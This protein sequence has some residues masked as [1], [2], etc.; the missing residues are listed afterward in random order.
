VKVTA[1]LVSHNGARW[2]PAV[3]GGLAA[4]TRKVDAIVAVDTGSQDDSAELVERAIGAPVLRLDPRTPY[5]ESVR[6]ALESAA[7]AEPDEWVWLLHDDSNPAPECLETL[8][9]TA[10]EAPAEVAVL[11]PKHR[12]WPSLKRLLEVGVTLTGTGQRETGLERGEYDQGQHD[13]PHRV[14]AVNTAGML[15]RR[16]VLETVGLDR[17]LPVFGTDL[18]FGWRVARAG[19]STRVVPDAVIFHVEASR[20]DRRES[21][22]VEHPGRQEREGAQYT[23][24]VNSPGWTI[25]FRSARMILGGLL[26]A[27][28]LLLVR[29]PGE[30]AD[31]VAALL[32]IFLRPRRVLRAR[33]DRAGTATVSH[34]EIR[35]LLAPFWLPYRHGLDYVTDVGVAIATSVRE[36]AARRRPPGVTESTPFWERVLRTPAVWVLLLALIAGRSYFGGEPL[37]GGALLPVPDS[38]THWWQTWGSWHSDL[39]IGTHAAGPAYLLPLAIL[40]TLLLGQVGLVIQLIFVLAVPVAFVGALHLLRRVCDGHGAPLWGAATYALLPVVSGS[41][42]QGRLGTVVGAAVLPW[43]VTAALGIGAGAAEANAAAAARQAEADDRGSH[44]ADIPVDPSVAIKRWRAAWRAAL[45]AWLLVAFVPPAWLV[46]ALLA[47]FAVV[48]G[49]AEGRKRELAIVTLVPLVVVL[50][51]ALGTLRAPSAWLVEAGRAATLPA[52]P[53]FFDLILG[54]TGSVIEAPGWFAIGLPLAAVVAF[55]RSDTR[56]RVLQVWVVVLAAAIVLAASSRV[57]VTLPGVPFEFRPWPGFLILLI[58]AGFVAIAAIAGDGVLRHVRGASIGWRQ[59]VA[60]VTV[61]VAMVVP[62]LGAGWWLLR[63]SDDLLDHAPSAEIP[64]YQQELAAGNDLTGVLRITGGLDRGIDYR[65]LRSGPERLGDDGVLA[66]TEPAPEFGKL[67]ERLLSDA[68][69]DDVPLLASY[70][71]KYVYAPP[72]VAGVVSGGMD[73]ASGLGGASGPARGSRAWVVQDDTTL[74]SVDDSRAWLR[75]IWI[76]IS[77]LALVTTAVL[78]APERRR[79]R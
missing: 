18:D 9:A 34:A 73:A 63:G 78:A 10:V 52:D 68:R 39:G 65:V 2:L 1:I 60:V 11:G 16:S 50:P 46:I 28:G 17:Y 13:E 70:G 30:A 49:F 56:A 55:L 54:R 6:A 43:L 51:W 36:E 21:E 79:R 71:V 77:L 32:K 31:E 7:P 3:L 61:A 74:S 25:P 40:G 57:P 41:L 67:V 22:L 66:M 45:L 59:P 26:R 23:L 44:A 35:P 8:V 37:H 64:M 20:Q 72:P 69:D 5:A 24:L 38:V 76:T 42:A 15:V 14:L 75:P 4:S 53:G 62:V 29:A 58:Q 12:E 33:R 27:L 47:L 48:G 19:Y